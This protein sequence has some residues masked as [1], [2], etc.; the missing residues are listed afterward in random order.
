[1]DY[2]TASINENHETTGLRLEAVEYKSVI[3]NL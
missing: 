3:C 1:M 2:R